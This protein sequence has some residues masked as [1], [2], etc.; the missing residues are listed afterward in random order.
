MDK[1][2]YGMDSGGMG[3]IGGDMGCISRTAGI[4]NVL[5]GPVGYG[6]Y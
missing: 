4:W 6:M 2:R 3:W 5:V 1:W